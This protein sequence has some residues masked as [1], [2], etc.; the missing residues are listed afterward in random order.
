MTLTPSRK[1]S[2]RTKNRIREHGPH[3]EVVR[4]DNAMCLH[5]RQAAF[6]EAPDGWRGWLPLDELQETVRATERTLTNDPIDW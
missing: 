2:S 5:G 3:F 1:A 4:V 6:V